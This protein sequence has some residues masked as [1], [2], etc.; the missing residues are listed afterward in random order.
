MDV[1]V[2]DFMHTWRII[3]SDPRN[4]EGCRR[5]RK[6]MFLRYICS[7]AEMKILVSL[8]KFSR[9]LLVIEEK[10]SNRVS[11]KN[12]NTLPECVCNFKILTSEDIAV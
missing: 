12:F 8:L 7:P 5:M 6:R 2:C 1:R 10:E 4:D 3:R 9:N 11:K